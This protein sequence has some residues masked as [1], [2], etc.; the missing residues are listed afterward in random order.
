MNDMITID[1]LY[2]TA[3]TKQ[4]VIAP[5]GQ[6]RF[7]DPKTGEICWPAY[8]CVAPD[9]PGRSPDGTPAL[10]TENAAGYMVKPDGA[11]A[12]DVNT[13]KAGAKPMDGYCPHCWEARNLGSKKPEERKI[14]QEQYVKLYEL[15]ES[16]KRRLDLEEELRQWNE[17]L[18]VRV[19][20][21]MPKSIESDSKSK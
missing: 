18:K 11:I 19:N 6:G 7:L 16:K 13:A 14:Y 10:F 3:N 15:P 1:G 20:A 12:F 17:K 9:C 2:F 8:C 5:S 4:R 21:P